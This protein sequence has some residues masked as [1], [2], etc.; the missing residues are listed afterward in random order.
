MDM[1]V[2]AR[3]IASWAIGRRTPGGRLLSEK[4]GGAG[5]SHHR[6]ES[7]EVPAP[8]VDL[9]K[10]HNLPRFEVLRINTFPGALASVRLW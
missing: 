3:P 10:I 6:R 4:N 7:I 5:G 1:A 2:A 9:H 8:S